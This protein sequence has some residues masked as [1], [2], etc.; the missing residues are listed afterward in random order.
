MKLPLQITYRNMEPS[1]AVEESI[2]KWANKL[3]R[4]CDTIMRC[5]VVVEAPRK[6][7]QTGGHFHVR[8]DITVPGGELVINREPDPHHAYVDVYVCIRD[9]FQAAERQLEEYVC[10]R[11]GAIKVHEAVPHGRIAALVPEEDYGRIATPDGREIYFH[12]N[13]LLE[14]DFDK[15]EEGMEVRFSEEEGD[16]GPQASTVRLVGKHHPVG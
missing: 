3:D 5:T 12:R 11:K 9:A 4:V 16:H 15:L 8:L 2:R 1:E 6:H 13:S 7:R 14:A 10:R